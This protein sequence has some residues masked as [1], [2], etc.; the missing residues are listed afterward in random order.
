VLPGGR[1]VAHHQ[2]D[3]GELVAGVGDQVGD[4]G[5]QPPG[6]LRGPPGGDQGGLHLGPGAGGHPLPPVQRLLQEPAGGR[7]VPGLPAHVPEPAGDRRQVELVDRVGRVGGGQVGGHPVGLGVHPDRLGRLRRDLVPV[8]VPLLL[9]HPGHR[10][11]QPRLEPPLAGLPDPVGG[12]LE[13]LLP[14]VLEPGLPPQLALDAGGQPEQGVDRHPPLLPGDRLA[15]LRLLL[16]RLGQL[17]G[18][19]LGLLQ[20]VDLVGEGHR[21]GGDRHQ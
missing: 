6:V 10:P 4:G 5:G 14:E 18:L 13:Q 17:L 21:P 8:E 3:A 11:G 1:R 7:D 15:V 20:L 12:H 9:V 16:V 19:G 2:A